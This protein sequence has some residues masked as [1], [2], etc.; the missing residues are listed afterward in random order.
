VNIKNQLGDTALMW[1]A[2]AGRMA[3]VKALIEAKADL[4]LQD[5]SGHTALMR[6][7][8]SRHRDV[9][10]LLIKAGADQNITNNEGQ[11]AL[12]IMAAQLN[13]LSLIPGFNTL[14]I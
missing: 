10:T 4:N 11:T 14:S 7:V 9:M 6:A 12:E 8:M 1:A 5:E 13:L 3:D 2:A